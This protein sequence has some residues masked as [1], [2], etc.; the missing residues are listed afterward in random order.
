MQMKIQSA[1]FLSPLPIGLALLASVSL[2][3]SQIT[4]TEDFESTTA[5]DVPTGWATVGVSANG[6]YATDESLGNPDQCAILTQTAATTSPF[7]RV[8]L[9]N[10]G[11]AFDATRPMTATFDFY[12]GSSVNYAGVNFIVGD[13]RNS[14]SATAPNKF[15]NFQL[16]RA[17]FGQRL[18]VWDAAANLVFNGD[19]NNQYAISAQTW[20]TATFT[21]TPTSGTTGT[22]TFTWDAASK[23]ITTPV[24]FTFD[25]PEA[26]FGFGAMRSD[27]PARFD[28]ISI[29]AFP[30]EALFWDTNNTAEGAGNP[31]DGDW[32]DTTAN[33]NPNADGTGTPVA[34]IPGGDAIFS[35]GSDAVDPFIVTVDGTQEFRGLTFN[36]GT[37]TLTGGILNIVSD[38]AFAQVAAGITATIESAI[39][40]DGETRV[41]SKS[42]VGTLI[43]SGD[44]SGATESSMSLDA[45]VTQFDVSDS[46]PGSGENLTVNSDATLLFGPSF[47]EA[48]IPAALDRVAA[49][50]PGTIGADNQE[51][52]DF[53]FSDS[54]A[55]LTAAYLGA[56]GS[57]S[58]SGTLTPNGTTYRLGGGGGT[59]TMANT[60]ALTGT[61]SAVVRENVLLASANNHESGTNLTTGSFLTLGNDNS[62]GSGTLTISGES[63]VAAIGTVATTNPVS[64]NAD[65]TIGGTGTLSLG[66]VTVNNNRIMTNNATGTT[67]I[68]QIGVTSGNRNLTFQGS[69]TTV[70]SGDIANGNGNVVVSGGTLVLSGSNAGSGT[71]NL[72]NATLQLN[73]DS[74]GGL[75]SGQLSLSSNA[76]VL[77]AVNADRTISNN[78]TLNSSPTISGSQSLTINGTMTVNNNRALTNN[79][80]GPGKVLTFADITRDGS[81]NR[82]LTFSGNG[83]T[84]VN[85]ILVLGSGNVTKNGNGTLT[86]NNTTTYTGNTTVNNAGTLLINGDSSASSGNVT[87]NN[88]ATLGGSGSIGGNVTIT[89]SANLAPGTSVGTLAIEG[90][91]TVSAMAGGAGQFLF[92]LDAIDASD[93]VEVGGTLAIGDGVL[94]LNDFD[95]TDLGGLQNGTY[96]LITSSGITG[97]LDTS[98]VEGT[99]GDANIEL[100]ISG[101]NVVL[102]VSG[103][104]GGTPPTLVSIENDADDSPIETN[105]PVTYTLTFSNDMDGSTF[106]AGD[107]GNNGSSSISIGAITEV[108]PDVFTVVVTP[109]NPGTLIFRIN[110]G[111][112]IEDID[113]LALNTTTA[114]ID[115]TQ[116]DV[117]NPPAPSNPYDTWAIGGELFG[118]DASGD[119]I[120][121]GLAFLLGADSPADSMLDW[122]ESLTA[123]NGDLTLTFT[124]RNAE[125]RGDATLSVE[126][127]NDLVGWTKVLIPEDD[128]ITVVG[129]VTFDVDQGDPLNSVT[130][131]IASN[132][133]DG[134]GKIFA[135]LVGEDAVDE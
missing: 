77:Q 69:G 126:Y 66:T 35:A 10:D 71:T 128:G 27:T 93:K 7:P 62:L 107:F 38:S 78:V 117:E 73:N 112:E 80:T 14:A 63:T 127:G 65:F 85:G 97:T 92:E 83:D 90:N 43:L 47:G 113:G 9:V 52:T 57:V 61:N 114:I 59:L 95:F 64:A 103:L 36:N 18:R 30:A 44:N 21:W 96:T 50:S 75:S 56:V 34:W 20:T 125:E 115:T 53:D 88:T 70:V 54:G 46:I 123:N 58:Y 79:I 120:A 124:M 106:D 87:V 72:N 118:D 133:A 33:W 99:L 94:G 86:L 3:I 49:A 23:G 104:S 121:N 22:F 84:I 122:L 51:T 19:G 131:T 89:G 25:S 135:R 37:P 132:A 6:T 45:G 8:Y 110:Q 1:P 39:T 29:T 31:A 91:L 100:Q 109:T 76:G 5:P 102:A 98:D 67:T 4:I 26:Y 130:I 12:V 48:N 101:D 32:D 82:N 129:D 17:T 81:N 134:E 116:I 13:V 108:S 28:N 11:I 68:G 15:L 2:A 74:N 60:N 40:D 41:L 55:D 105:T 16:Q 111:A 24:S 119:G 42:G